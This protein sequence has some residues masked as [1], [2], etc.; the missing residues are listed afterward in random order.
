METVLNGALF[1]ARTDPAFTTQA[2]AAWSRPLLMTAD[3]ALLPG[4]ADRLPH[5]AT[6]PLTP[7][8]ATD[9]I[10]AELAQT[11]SAQPQADCLI[12][13]M[14]WAMNAL[15]GG[16]TIERW[17]AIADTAAER[18]G[19]PVLSLYDRE[20][21]VEDQLAAVFR[22]HRVFVAPSG[23]H[24][25][26]HWL[27]PRLLAKA[28]L[29]E[30]L[31]FLLGRVVPEFADQ[32]FQQSRRPD[33]ARGA[34]PAWVPSQHRAVAA[35]A[36]ADRWHIHCLGP[37][38]V[39]VAGGREIDWTLPGAAPRKSRALF[40]YLLSR[41]DTGCHADQLCEFLWPDNLSEDV[42]RARLRHAV[43][44]LR[45]TLGGGN[46][47]LRDRDSYRLNVPRG[48]WIDIRAFEQLCRRG[49]SLFKSGDLEAA[50]RVYEGAERLYR[51][52]L[53]EDVGLDY[54]TSE[55]DDWCLPKRVWLHDM[56]VKLHH[57]MARVLRELGR[58]RP[59]LDHAQ[60]A[61]RLDPSSESATIEAMTI[62]AAQ[63]RFEAIERQ[64]QQYH[65]ANSEHGDCDTE[66]RVEAKAR[67]LLRDQ[68]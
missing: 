43:S 33:L 23:V 51:G 11:L 20:L 59:A 18:H 42:K 24:D 6:L 21:L 7:E 17:G 56:A 40:A 4:I 61:L 67:A 64:V 12:V 9:R 28:P 41:G 26:P 52:D 8:A 13:D 57:D 22:A 45:K 47:V 39:Y 38:K 58:L 2:L 62:F 15:W 29:D 30:Q 60:A 46:T 34:S 35:E 16:A 25:N 44:M 54:V 48:S 5:V 36:S 1:H 55:Y 65:K 49:L 53:F 31:S 14:G 19:L 68:T 37:L 27:P 50:I 66:G 32:P 10:L 63:G 3:P